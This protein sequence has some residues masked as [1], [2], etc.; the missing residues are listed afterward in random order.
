[1]LRAAWRFRGFLGRHRV[2]FAV[3]ALLVV[4]ETLADLA[5]P[6]P[7]KVIIDGAINHKPQHG[8]L[9]RSIAGGTQEPN[10]ILVR[11]L[12]ATAILVGLS[13][14]F[15]FSSD[16]IMNGAGQRVVATVRT[17]LFGHLQRLSLSFHDRQRVGDLVGRLT[18]DIDRSESMLV[19]MFDTLIPNVV[20]LVG[21]GVVMILIDPT[22]GLLALTI[23]PPLFL[24][25]Y[26]YTL[27][28]KRASRQAREADAGLA[29]LANET[30]SAV[31]AVQSF[32]R[33]DY[34]D[35][36]FG[37]RNRVSLGAGLLAIRLKA[38]F[39]PLV[40]IVSL[41]GTVLVTYVGVQR[42]IHGQMT[43]GV[44]LVFLSYLKSL[45]KP[46]RALSKLAYLISQGTASAE[47]VHEMLKNEQQLPVHPSA[48]PAPR[49][50]G[51]VELRDITFCYPGASRPVLRGANLVVEAGEHIGIVGRTGAG[52]S[53]LVSLVPRFY[54]PG[55][56]AV[57]VD[58]IDVRHLELPTVRR[59]V[60]LVLQDPVLFYGTILDNM[61]YGDP[62]A[63]VERVWD[64][65]AAA[66][67][68]EFLE[69]LPDGMLTMLGERGATLSGGQRQRIAIARAM[70]ADAPILI[71]DEPTTGLD[72]ESEGL[73]LDGLHRL[74]EGRTTFVISHHD[75][76]L[77][78]VDRILDVR[79]GQLHERPK[80]KD[81]HRTTATGHRTRAT[82][83]DSA[84]HHE[85][86]VP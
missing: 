55:A 64:V 82:P 5:Q 40:D 17:T 37:E 26:R 62:E 29:A 36:R 43:L 4:A 49:L 68:T 74:T 39:T 72:R 12:A 48:R 8:W 32:S 65:A 20:M 14:V 60:S 84:A 23:A 58:G 67:V 22:F 38:S 33:E 79:D 53:T 59:Q 34:E 73:V 41:G 52:K 3:G 11:A 24:I 35:A 21:L 61:L 13:A 86:V 76:A 80:Q 70:L 10:Q 46:M 27:R 42:V 77:A 1:M 54:D 75:A 71:L 25:T 51:R 30:L 19:A 28:I 7:L 18:V 50:T 47:R 6:W 31:R 9:A 44:L 83:R 66:H 69:R 56:G 81:R 63:T 15:D 45:Y 2:A 78:N 16:Y 57:L 85:T